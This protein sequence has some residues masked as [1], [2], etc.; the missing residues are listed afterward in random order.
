M[1]SR[2]IAVEQERPPIA[3]VHAKLLSRHGLLECQ[4]VVLLFTFRACESVIKI[5]FDRAVEVP[6]SFCVYEK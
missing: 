2:A 4:P 5:V 6:L 3:M 1:V